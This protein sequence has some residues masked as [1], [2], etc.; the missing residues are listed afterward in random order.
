ME[1]P[2][3]EHGALRLTSSRG[4]AMTETVLVTWGL[5]LLIAVV[6]Q[7]FFV[8][9]YSFH[10]AATAHSRLFT[11]VAYPDNKPTVPYE[12]RWTSKF[13]GAFEYVPVV[14]FFAPYGLTRDNM[15]IR[16]T[17]GRPGGY[18]RIKLGRGTKPDTL[19]GIEGILSKDA[20]TYVSQAWD[21]LD[22]ADRAA[23]DATPPASAK[24]SRK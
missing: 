15:R 11:Q 2:M 8:D 16:T 21:G 23:E 3:A 14:A 19:K 10:L 6:V 24:G 20:L 5:I 22:F 7:V 9:L 17:Q 4:Q 1:Q 18:K 13:E 12:T